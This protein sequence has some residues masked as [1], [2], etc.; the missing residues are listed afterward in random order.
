MFASRNHQLNPRQE[1]LAGLLLALCCL[2]LIFY[3]PISGIIQNITRSFFF[4]FLAPVFFVKIIL[5]K[6]LSDFGFNFKNKLWGIV[7]SGLILL[8][9]LAG[10]YWIIHYSEFKPE[11]NLPGYISQ[12]F[13]AFLFYEFVL[14]NLF[15]FLQDFFFCGFLQTLLKPHSEKITPFLITLIY[16]LISFLTKEPALN[17]AVFSGL[18]LVKSFLSHQTGSFLY[19]YFSSLIFTII[20]DSY[21]IH[22]LK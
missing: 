1:L 8:T 2:L 20:L 16:A 21:I 12:S 22:L 18:I 19:G 17:L 4:L 11:Y 15:F 13:A 10:V 7:F 9:A 6:N 3:F 5:K 14:I